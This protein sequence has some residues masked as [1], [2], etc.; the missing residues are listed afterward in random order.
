M[1]AIAWIIIACVVIFIIAMIVMTHFGSKSK[2]TKCGKFPA[3][4]IWTPCKFQNIKC[5]FAD[6]PKK[7]NKPGKP[8]GTKP[9]KPSS[10]AKPKL[11]DCKSTQDPASTPPAGMV[12]Y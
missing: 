10:Q 8:G 6:K 11:K 7:N 2:T 4:Y 3:K 1:N 5:R 9:G 12:L